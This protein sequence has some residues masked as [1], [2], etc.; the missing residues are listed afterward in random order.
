MVEVV[1]LEIVPMQVTTGTA[2]VLV[3]KA[4]SS[5]EMHVRKGVWL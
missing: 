1:V 5:S 3:L 4:S 2:A